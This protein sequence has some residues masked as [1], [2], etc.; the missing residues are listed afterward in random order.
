MKAEKRIET[1]RREVYLNYKKNKR[2]FPWRKTKE[3]K[4]L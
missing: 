4:V 1:F 2:N 3:K